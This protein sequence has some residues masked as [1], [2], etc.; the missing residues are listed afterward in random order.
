[1]ILNYDLIDDFQ[2]F[3]SM[4]ATA[5]RNILLGVVSADRRNFSAYNARQMFLVE[6]VLVTSS[7]NTIIYNLFSLFTNFTCFLLRE[8]G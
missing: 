5:G 2:P 3:W 7:K 6:N 1:M 4:K 8:N